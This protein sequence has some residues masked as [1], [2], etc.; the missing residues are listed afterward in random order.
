MHKEH[1][2]FEKPSNEDAKI[3]HYMNFSKFVSLL[4]SKMLFLTRADLFEDKFEGMLPKAFTI[5][6][7]EENKKNPRQLVKGDNPYADSVHKTFRF[8]VQYGLLEMGFFEFLAY[9]LRRIYGNVENLFQHRRACNS[10]YL[11]KTMQIFR[12]LYRYRCV[13]RKGKIY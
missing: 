8:K 10:I 12:R 6:F 11:Q 9:K 5:D 3:W 1:P 13:E 4:D 2:V 7:Q